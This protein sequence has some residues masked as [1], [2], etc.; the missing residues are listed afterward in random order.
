MVCAVSH[1]ARRHGGLTH[2]QEFTLLHALQHIGPIS[3]NAAH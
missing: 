3:G 1:Y 2:T